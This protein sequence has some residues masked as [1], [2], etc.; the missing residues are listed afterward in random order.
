[1]SEIKCGIYQYYTK[2]VCRHGNEEKDSSTPC[3]QCKNINQFPGMKFL[4]EYKKSY[5]DFEEFLRMVVPSKLKRN[6]I[7]GW[8]VLAPKYFLIEEDHVRMSDASTE[9]ETLMEENIRV[10]FPLVRKLAEKH[11]VFVGKWMIFLPNGLHAD[12][13][14]IRIARAHQEGKLGVA[15]RI[16]LM[17]I[18]EEDCPYYHVAF[19][20]NYDF[21]DKKTVFEIESN[22]R[23]IGIRCRMLYKPMAFSYCDIHSGNEWGMK[24]YIYTSTYDVKKKQSTIVKTY[25][26]AYDCNDDGDN[27]FDEEKHDDHDNYGGNNQ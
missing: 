12:L 7:Y 11:S 2:S 25:D 27:D 19:V 16:S 4:E 10:N 3:T 18:H 22:L 15:A 26:Y 17:S 5:S 8:I 23:D 21:R 13:T 1:M 24:P 20:Y 9:W 14:W 6:G